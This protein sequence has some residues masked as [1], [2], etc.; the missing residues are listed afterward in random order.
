MASQSHGICVA[1]SSSS[2]NLSQVGSS[3]NPIL[4]RKNHD[5]V[6]PSDPSGCM[7]GAELMTKWATISFPF[8]TFFFR[9]VIWLMAIMNRDWKILCVQTGPFLLDPSTVCVYLAF[10]MFNQ[11][12]VTH[13]KSH[14]YSISLSSHSPKS[15]NSA[16]RKE[17]TYFGTS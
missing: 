11:T 6:G 13:C 1:D 16:Y 17:I 5:R 9:G 7:E 10:A 4:K 8:S 12:H 3:V 14:V 15:T 2:R